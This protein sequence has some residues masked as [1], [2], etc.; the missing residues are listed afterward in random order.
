MVAPASAQVAEQFNITSPALIA[1]TTSIFVL[2]YCRYPYFLM[3]LNSFIIQLSRRS[4]GMYVEYKRE[5]RL[6]LA[7]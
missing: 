7:L 5:P 6:Y 1:M 4:I 2:G 3:E